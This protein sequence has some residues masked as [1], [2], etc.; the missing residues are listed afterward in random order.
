MDE[1]WTLDGWFYTKAG[2]RIGP[3]L[4]EYIAFLLRA[5]ELRPRE[6]VFQGWKKGEEYRLTECEARIA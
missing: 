2:K 4:P 5:E 3:V 6:K 1:Q